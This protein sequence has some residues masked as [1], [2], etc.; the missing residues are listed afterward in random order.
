MLR[1]MIVE[2][3]TKA[4]ATT[5]RIVVTGGGT[6]GH[7]T[8]ILAVIEHL[9]RIASVDILWLGSQRGPERDAAARLGLAYQ[10]VRTG[11]L[12]RYLSFETAVDAF[13]VPA[14]IAEAVGILRRFRPHVV[15]STGGFVGVP[16]VVA[17]RLL[18]IAS[19]THE[20]TAHLGLATRINSL[21]SDVVALSYAQGAAPTRLGRA[22]VVITGN[23][24]RSVVCSGNARRAF[25]RFELPIDPLL[26]YVT[27]GMRGAH[28]INQ[29]IDGSLESLLAM[30]SVIHQ[31][32]PHAAN[33]DFEL[34]RARQESLPHP[35]CGRY[36][37]VETVGDEIGDIYAAA[38]LVIGRAGAGTVAELA[39]VGKPSV[40]IPLPGAEEQRRN[41]L[42]L[43]N[44]GAAILLPQSQASPETLVATV[45]ALL[46]DHPRREAM[47]VAARGVFRPAA[48]VRLAEEI[49]RLAAVCR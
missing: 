19:L 11:K 16:A 20:Q 9:R 15:F 48:E 45:T 26:I 23:P 39:A 33:G 34:L 47:G 27:G 4:P 29:L 42:T 22:R 5:V 44:A 8:P 49:L 10:A 25:H 6:G 3:I 24:V 40:L 28:F 41:A 17:A 2:S 38:A 14:G 43:A 1:T 31:C 13:R 18:R 32:G 12:R 37:V 46:S 35:F 7:I 36:R 21:F 30:A